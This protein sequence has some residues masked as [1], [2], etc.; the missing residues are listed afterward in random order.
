MIKPE[1]GVGLASYSGDFAGN[2]Y[3]GSFKNGRWHGLGVATYGQNRSNTADALRCEGEF[4]DGELSG[5]AVM[6]W[7]N[8]SRSAGAFRDNRRNG[9]GVFTHPDGGRFEGQFVDGS[10][11]GYGVYWSSRGAVV[12]AGVWADNKLV[13]PLSSQGR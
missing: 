7:R 8:G 1:S 9:Y 4:V 11:A 12:G 10:F 3:A 5:F 6:H 2:E 13:T